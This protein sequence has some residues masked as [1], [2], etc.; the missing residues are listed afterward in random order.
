MGIKKLQAIS[1]GKLRISPPL[2]ISSYQIQQALSPKL[3]AARKMCSPGIKQ[4]PFSQ[5]HPTALGSG[6][7]LRNEINSSPNQTRLTSR[8]KSSS[9]KPRKSPPIPVPKAYQQKHP[10]AGQHPHENPGKFRGGDYSQLNITSRF[11]LPGDNPGS[12]NQSSKKFG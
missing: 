11:F 12:K 9:G 7:K 2:S 4:F 3:V 1:G 8:P 6:K 5:G 10:P